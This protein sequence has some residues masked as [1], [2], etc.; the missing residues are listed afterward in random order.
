MYCCA[1]V[2]THTHTDSQAFTGALLPICTHTHPVF[3][4]IPAS[5][6]P[7]TSTTG[8]YQRHRNPLNP[9]TGLNT[10]IQTNSVHENCLH[11]HRRTNLGTP[12]TLREA[13]PACVP[14]CCGL[15]QGQ[16]SVHACVKVGRVG[17]GNLWG[18]HRCRPFPIHSTPFSPL[19][20]EK[21]SSP[22]QRQILGHPLALWL[23]WATGLSPGLP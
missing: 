10:W 18:L 20:L 5:H 12:G 16:L 4:G 21:S 19:P 3:G 17:G 14:R 7:D 23:P 13:W 22:W 9:L 1:R 6:Y 15:S 11:M 2:H 8:I